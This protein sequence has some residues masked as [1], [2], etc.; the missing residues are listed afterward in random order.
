MLNREKIVETSYM[1][2]LGSLEEEFHASLIT[3]FT[4]IC[5]FSPYLASAGLVS[6][7]I[8]LAVIGLTIKIY[9]EITRR[10]ISRRV[11]S[12][13]IWKSLYSIVGYVGILFNT[14]IIAK[15][16]KGVKAFTNLDNI[17][18]PEDST[19]GTERAQDLTVTDVEYIYLVMFGLLIFKFA[20]SL[21]IPD[22]PKWIQKKIMREKLAQERA[23]K[24]YSR[25]VGK[26]FKKSEDE[27]GILLSEEQE[28]L[29]L[30]SFFEN[31]REIESL[32]NFMTTDDPSQKLAEEDLHFGVRLDKKNLL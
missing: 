4:F 15:I 5:L 24:K 10:P 16:N 11:S 29:S 1:L 17:Q 9:T 8:N 32:D 6:F 7:F 18:N 23:V 13:G 27:G 28:R 2:D 14:L 19:G 31:D 22:L 26:V 21:L 30:R 3:Q 12:I 20:L 25:L